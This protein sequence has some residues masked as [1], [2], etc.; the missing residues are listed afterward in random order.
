MTDKDATVLKDG[1]VVYYIGQE[2]IVVYSKGTDLWS[3]ETYLPPSSV[4][5]PIRLR[6]VTPYS[7]E[8]AVYCGDRPTNLA[9][10]SPFLIKESDLSPLERA[11]YGI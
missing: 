10:N 7:G 11:I 8:L 4:S 3:S 1:D 2:S 9:L 6:I 5:A